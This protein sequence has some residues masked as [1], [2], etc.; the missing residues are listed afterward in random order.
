MLPWKTI[1]DVIS[2][3]LQAR[4]TELVDG[5]VKWPCEFHAAQTIRLKVATSSGTGGGT[6]GGTGFDTGTGGHT[7]KLVGTAPF[8]PA[9]IQDLGDVMPKLLDLKAKSK[10]P[11]QFHVRIE[12]GDG[13]NQP[14]AS[15]VE[16]LNKILATIKDGFQVQ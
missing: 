14:Q 12:F 16:Q 1:R 4:F 15:L 5:S 2:G 13:T 11:F 7:T 3:S 9:E 10:V 8:E 6:G